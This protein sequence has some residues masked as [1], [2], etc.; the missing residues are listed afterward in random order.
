ML[1][2]KQRKL[3]NKILVVDDDA[4]ILNSVSWILRKNDFEVVTLIDCRKVLE[5]VRDTKPDLILLDINLGYC[6]GRQ[7][8][9]QL[10]NTNLFNHPILLFSANPEMVE[11]VSLYKADDFIQKPFAIKEFVTTIREHLLLN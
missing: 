6:D 2:S 3:M 10:K 7:L 1:S 11:S 8:C 9:L 5:T 4:D